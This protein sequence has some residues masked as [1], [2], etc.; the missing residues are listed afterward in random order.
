MCPIASM[1]TE[2]FKNKV[3][4]TSN[5]KTV[6]TG[7]AESI[8]GSSTPIPNRLGVIVKALGE[9]TA[10]VYIGGNGVTISTGFELNAKEATPSLFVD[11]VQKIYAIS[12]AAG[13]KVCWFVE[14]DG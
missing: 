14:T 6:P 5:Q 4:L 2:S 1:M 7:T 13:Q 11:N 8:A 3:A 10:A 12:A 9:N